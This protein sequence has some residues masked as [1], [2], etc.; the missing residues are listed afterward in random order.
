MGQQ[1]PLPDTLYHVTMGLHVPDDV[2]LPGN[3]GR[4]IEGWGV[5]HNQFYR[6][7]ALERVRAAEFPDKPSRMRACYVCEDEA[8]AHNFRRGG[9]QRPPDH[10]Y[11]V[12][13]VDTSAPCHRGDMMF[14][15]IMTS[16]RT[17]AG[18]DE[19]ARRYWRGEQAAT[20]RIEWVIAGAIVVDARLSR[21]AEDD[22]KAPVEAG[23][24]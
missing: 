15:D 5:G 1:P 7:Y 3:W 16:Q 13:L 2:I 11:A 10:V 12:R 24:D 9:P 21:I 18:V 19:C 8:F 4:I 22:F 17:F 6:E 14:I 23:H 20:P